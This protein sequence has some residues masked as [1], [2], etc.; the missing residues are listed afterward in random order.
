MNKIGIITHY[1]VHNHG[2]VLQLM[3]LKK[4]LFNFGIEARALQFDKNYDFIGLELQ[5]KYK[6]SIKSA[7]TYLRYLYDKGITCTLYNYKKHRTL[8]E[9]KRQQD[10]IGEYYSRSPK[11]D[12]VI[13]GSD[14]VFALHTGPTPVFFGHCLP[15]DYVV[16][17]AGSFGPTTYQD[18]IS[19]H[20]MPFVSSGLKSMRDITVRDENSADIVEKITGNR[21]PMVMDP[22]LLYGYINEIEACH[23]PNMSDYLLVYAYDNRMNDANEVAKIRAYAQ[24]KDLKVVS[25]GFFHHWCDKNI[26]VDPITLLA[27]FKHAK[28][29]ITDTFHGC[30]LSLITN[31]QFVAIPRDTNRLKLLNLMS[32]YDMESRVCQSEESIDDI[33]SPNIDYE[34]VNRIIERR[35][36]ESMG[37]L[38]KSLN[39]CNIAIV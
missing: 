18:I 6:I 13:I 31:S 28:E 3:A 30:V 33:M 39:Q 32:E 16:S 21:P 9:F 7:N 35:R 36:E 38:R 17:Y 25:V 15:T 1:D 12:A 29:V 26:N 14:E 23:R 11:L 4:V 34:T 2:A 5:A 20:S 10:L 24:K 8:N 22:V 27:Y 37:H 19:S